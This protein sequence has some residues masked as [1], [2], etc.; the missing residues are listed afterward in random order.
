MTKVLEIL[1]EQTYEQVRELVRRTFPDKRCEIGNEAVDGFV[2]GLPDEAQLALCGV[3]L[4]A[5]EILGTR[6][7]ED[8]NVVCYYHVAA[9]HSRVSGPGQHSFVAEFPM[10]RVK[11]PEANA[12]DMD[13]AIGRVYAGDH[14]LYTVDHFRQKYGKTLGKYVKYVELI[15]PARFPAHLGSR[16]S[17]VSVF[18]LYGIQGELVSYVL[19]AG[20]A[21][22]EPMVCYVSQDASALITEPCWYE[23]TP[24]SDEKNWYVGG[25]KWKRDELSSVYVEV[26]TERNERAHMAVEAVFSREASPPD[27]IL[28]AKLTAMAGLRVAAIA[29]SMGRADAIMNLLAPFGYELPWIK[30]PSKKPSKSA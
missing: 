27:P 2:A 4:A 3:K 19:E 16:F 20:M 6:L 30:K 21:T 11:L 7:P 17:A 25:A 10:V 23:P 8:P 9:R 28:P 24:F 26:R 15:T 29:H 18:A 13:T 1:G 22:G 14:K 12:R 5:E